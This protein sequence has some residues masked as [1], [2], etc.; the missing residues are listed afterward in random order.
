LEIEGVYPAIITPFNDRMDLNVDAYTDFLTTLLKTDIDGI[1]ITGTTGEAPYLSY[2][3]RKIIYRETSHIVGTK[4]TIICG[5]GDISLRKTLENCKLAERFGFDILLILTPYYFKLS[6]AQL[7]EY[8]REVCEY[9]ETPI[10]LYNFPQVT[11][12]RIEPKTVNDLIN[13]KE[14]IGIK[15]SSGDLRYYLDIRYLLKNKGKIFIG[16]AKISLAT[17]YMGADGLILALANILPKTFKKIYIAVKEGRYR[18]AMR[19]YREIYPIMDT[20]ERIGIP[21]IKYLLSKLGINVGY[22]R[23]PLKRI[24]YLE[25]EDKLLDI[26][27]EKEEY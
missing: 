15:D 1:V 14:V 5:V 6:Q 18:D 17:L 12:I 21:F 10:L 19:I 7:K 2:E 20:F 8:Y 11:G 27:R 25:N 9:V 16:N 3:E 23:A 4:K 22:P 24:N 26:I 13:N